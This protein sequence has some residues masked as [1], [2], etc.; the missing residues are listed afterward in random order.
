RD[1]DARSAFHDLHIETARFVEAKRL[2]FVEAAMFGLRLPVRDEGDVRAG[3]HRTGAQHRGPYRRN[4]SQTPH[5]PAPSHDGESFSATSG[6]RRLSRSVP[7]G[8]RPQWRE[9]A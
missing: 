8:V 1:V 4:Y 6:P 5:P 3:L 9:D 2:R 7:H